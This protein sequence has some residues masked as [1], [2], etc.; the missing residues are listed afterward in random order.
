MNLGELGLDAFR[1]R[2]DRQ[3]TI[4]LLCMMASYAMLQSRSAAKTIISTPRQYK[5]K[6]DA[7]QIYFQKATS[8]VSQAEEID[9]RNGF[10]LDTKGVSTCVRLIHSWVTR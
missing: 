5:A 8:L 7:K 9:A 10:V 2:D 6:G 1:S 3:S 4:P